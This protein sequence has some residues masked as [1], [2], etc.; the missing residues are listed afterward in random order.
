M[1]LAAADLRVSLFGG[2][3]DLPSFF[4][5]E[6]LGGTCVSTTIDK[7]VYV[8]I[9]KTPNKHIKVSYN[10]TEIVTD[11][12]NL[13]HDRIREAL[14]YFKIYSNIEISTFADIPSAGSGLGSSSA[15]SA[16]LI[17]A[18][19]KFR[20]QQSKFEFSQPDEYDYEYLKYSLA[21]D[22]VNLEITRCKENIGWQDQYASVFGGFNQINF[23]KNGSTE[24]I[25]FK[26]VDDNLWRLQSKLLM[27]RVGEPRNTTDVL[28][29]KAH[30]NKHS[31]VRQLA[32]IARI[33]PTLIKQQEYD[34]L[35]QLLDKSWKIKRETNELV[36]NDYIDEV[37][38][39][40]IKAGAIGG[41]LLGAGNSG[42]MLF[43]AHEEHHE[44]ILENM[45]DWGISSFSF[46][47]S[48]LP[49]RILYPN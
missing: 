6:E 36:T 28:S 46:T 26:T 13:K 31:M 38:Q 49:A 23:N 45:A 43:L 17:L 22:V 30:K 34:I 7:S 20:D 47:F 14:K 11:I 33:A 8:A 48:N 27:F 41:K 24:V 42:H 4:K 9:H 10:D 19:H 1:I 2:S 44:R 32:E 12:N 39:H 35:G 3:S 16:A 40:G 25:P 21:E 37:Y 15:F 29:S 5:K 18:L